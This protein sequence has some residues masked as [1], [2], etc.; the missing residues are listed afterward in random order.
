MKD[1]RAGFGKVKESNLYYLF[2][3]RIVQVFFR[4]AFQHLVK[5][6]G[7]FI[8]RHGQVVEQAG[9]AIAGRGAGHFTL[10]AGHKGESFLEHG[11]HVGR[12]I[13]ATHQEIVAG[14]AAH[15]SPIHDAVFPHGVVAEVGGG[16]M[17]DGVDGTL[18]Q[19]GFAVGQLHTDIE[20][21]YHLTAHMVFAGNIHSAQQAQMVD[22]ETGYFLHGDANVIVKEKEGKKRSKQ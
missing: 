2:L 9:A 1:E 7:S 16:Q 14:E 10:I 18:P 20:G 11:Q 19:Y 17:L 8:S 22:S 15:G 12:G 21:G 13:V 6:F 5:V 4:G 3:Q